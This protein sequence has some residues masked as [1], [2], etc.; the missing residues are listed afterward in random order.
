M[1]IQFPDCNLSLPASFTLYTSLEPYP[2]LTGMSLNFL[3]TPRKIG[4]YINSCFPTQDEGLKCFNIINISYTEECLTN[5][6]HRCSGTFSRPD[7]LYERP[8][9]FFDMKMFTI[10]QVF[11]ISHLFSL[12]IIG[13]GKSAI[14]AN[15]KKLKNINVV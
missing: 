8:H 9:N 2:R 1:I 11:A 3:N 13:L 6:T 7:I 12:F 4:I 5:T 15:T 10:A 14:G